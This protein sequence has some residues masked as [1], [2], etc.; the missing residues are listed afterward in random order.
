MA[1]FVLLVALLL[2]LV[3]EAWAGDKASPDATIPL[4][5]GVELPI[6]VRVAFRV[7][8][9]LR[10]AEVAGQGRFYVEVTQRWNDPRLRF[11]AVERGTGRIDRVGQDADG[12][13]KTIWIPALSVDNQI[14]E[15]ESR[16]AAVSTYANGDVVFIERYESNFRFRM[17]MD[18]FPF[19]TQDLT[20][21][22]SLPRY[23]KQDAILIATETDRQLSGIEQALAVVDW[24]P[25]R[26]RF[27]NEEAM[28]WNA[29]SYS[30]LNA[31]I[32]LTRQSERYLLRIFIPIMAVLAASIFV[33]WAPGL[34]EKDKGTQI[35]SSLLALAA[36]SFTFEASFPG[37]ISLNTPV[38]QII[39]LGYLYLVVVLLFDAIISTG[40]RRPHSRYFTLCMAL[41]HEFRWALP[42][43]MVVVSVGAAVRAIPG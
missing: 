43:L 25:L 16:T 32:T 21:E 4:P 6:R 38:A 19:D 37:A 10:I 3:S 34:T 39:S 12:Y 35:F 29:R 15:R 30:R 5:D 40:C 1:R 11:D 41:R 18:A 33:L 42:A 31:T 22:F 13:L 24:K 2:A 14:G 28:G 26:L 27:S 7:L 20:L 17:N 8:N 9:V 36:L 23:A